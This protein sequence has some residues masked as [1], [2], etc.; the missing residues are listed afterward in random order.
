MPLV[1]LLVASPVSIDPDSLIDKTR[2]LPGSNANDQLYAA[3]EAVRTQFL[4]S[5]HMAFVIRNT[6][7]RVI[8]KSDYFP[9][10]CIKK[11][12]IEKGNHPYCLKLDQNCGEASE[13]TFVCPCGLTIFQVPILWDDRLLGWVQGGYIVQSNSKQSSEEVYMYDMPESGSFGILQLLRK[14][15][16]AIRNFCEFDQYRRELFETEKN[17]SRP[18]YRLIS[19][20]LWRKMHLPMDFPMKKKKN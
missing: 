3:V 14:V 15:A 13:N 17:L 12:G 20:S 18:S 10:P 11:C 7:G 5:L 4:E 2:P 9:E 1:H 19:C 8:L 16:K 6:S